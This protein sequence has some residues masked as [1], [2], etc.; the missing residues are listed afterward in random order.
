M[1]AFPIIVLAVS[2]AFSAI[3]FADS[4]VVA[5]AWM[6]A[7]QNGTYLFKMVPPEV[8]WENNKLSIQ[9]QA[10]GVAYSLSEKGDLNEIWRAE[11]W[12]AFEGKISNDGKN[13]VCFG[14]WASD[15]DGH[16][17]LAI[18]FYDQGKLVKEYKVKDLIKNT[19]ALDNTTS[20]YT[21]RAEKQ[22]EPTDF[23]PGM[24]NHFHLVMADKTTYVFEVPTGA[25]V[26]TGTDPAARSRREVW[27]E[28]EAE[29]TRQ[30]QALLERSP[31]RKDYEEHFVISEVEA[32]KGLILGDSLEGPPWTA[33]LTPKNKLAHPAKVEVVFPIKE[34]HAEATLK[35]QEMIAAMEKALQHPFVA[36]RFKN[37]A[38]GLRMRTQGDRLHWDTREL[39]EFIKQAKGS[40]PEDQVL[41]HWIYA[42]IDQPTEPRS[43]SFYLNAQTGEIIYKEGY[44]HPPVLVLL[45]AK[46]GKAG[47]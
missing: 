29:A 41:R 45:D 17:D 10:F 34:D 3:G 21:W 14:P 1:K 42:I 11:G 7:S 5:T 32:M 27:R 2:L 24:D 22:T 33:T 37:G 46:G 31:L 39:R 16:T 6:D 38:T 26:S 43:R 8:K 23:I 30:G 15:L 4:P 12:Y 35:A 19:G 25:I 9:R 44:E 40:E 13:L 28:E 36:E 18:A 47:K 20:H